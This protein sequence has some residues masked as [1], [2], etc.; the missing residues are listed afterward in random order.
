VISRS[1]IWRLDQLGDARHG[2]L[3]NN[4]QVSSPRVRGQYP[5]LDS[6]FISR[7]RLPR[8]GKASIVAI[9]GLAAESL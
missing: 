4:D 9:D 5:N 6:S 2:D 1:T 7:R 8:R 3:Q